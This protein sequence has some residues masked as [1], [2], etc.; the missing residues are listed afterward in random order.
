[1]RFEKVF[2]EE[3]VQSHPRAIELLK[4]I[5]YSELKP[6][7]KVEDVFGRVQKPYLS[8]REF[9]NVFIGR[10]EGALVKPAPPAYGRAGEPHY[11]F[12]HAYNCIYE[13]EYCY[14][15]GYFQSPDLVFFINH[16]EICEEIDR[17]GKLEQ[18]KSPQHRVWFHAGEFSDSLALSHWTG[19]W[20][21]YWEFFADRPQFFLELRT[22]STQIRDFL[23]KL[24]PLPNTIISF[25]LSPEKS[26]R[27]LDHRTPSLEARLKA[28]EALAQK[29]YRI[30]IHLDP[31]VYVP[32]FLEDYRVLIERISQILPLS[33]WEYVSLG[34]VRFSKQSF[35]AFQKHYPESSILVYPLISETNGKIRYPAKLREPVLKQV[36]QLMEATG[37]DPQ[38]IYYCME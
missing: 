2:I 9:L 3:Q 32:D 37:L 5:K 29:G 6:I 14:L 4:K 31:I 20:P 28:I 13:C 18:A 1:M 19:E 36:R 8:K 26:A 27:Q 33:Q 30:G 23:E 34:V 7:R 38:R 16:E 10:K 11:Y 17:I 21:I 35:R 25:S 24:K 15:Q 22:K 12:V